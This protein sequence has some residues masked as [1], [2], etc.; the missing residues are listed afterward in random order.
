MTS[1]NIGQEKLFAFDVIERNREALALLSD[2]IFYFGEIGPQ[3][4]ETARL[5]TKLL[6][7]EGF[8]VTRGIS[9][10]PT[11]FLATFGSGAPVIAI[12]TEYDA[13]P[14]N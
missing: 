2:S 5:M 9:G 6:E 13:N 1:A 12:H 8:A 11:S 4:T 3:E 7:D 14:D 10:F